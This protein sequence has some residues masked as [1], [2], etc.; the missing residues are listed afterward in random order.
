[1]RIRNLPVVPRDLFARLD[2]DWHQYGMFSGIAT[3]WWVLGPNDGS[4]YYVVPDYNGPRAGTRVT[5]HCPV[6]EAEP[7]DKRAVR[8]ALSFAAQQAALG[9]A[10]ALAAEQVLVEFT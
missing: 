8:L 4:A 5:Y 1:M 10:C 9:I 2:E 6:I 7:H 3:Q